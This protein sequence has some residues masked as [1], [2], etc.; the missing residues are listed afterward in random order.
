REE[1]VDS[2]LV[3]A[4]R[5]FR[6]PA[7]SQDFPVVNVQADAR[8][9]VPG[10]TATLIPI[11]N[12]RWLVTTSGTRGGPPSAK[13]EEFEAFARQVR[14]PVVA[15]LI[16]HA[17]PLTDVHISRSTVNR[18]RFFEALTPWPAG[19]VAMGDAVA[20]YNPVYGHGMTVAAQGATA[21]RRA[22]DSGARDDPRLARRT[23][24]AVA[25]AVEG[26]WNLATGQDLRYPG[27]T[28]GQPSAAARLLHGYMDRLTRTSTSQPDTA[29]ALLDAM[30]LSRPLSSLMRPSVVVR[31]LR[32]PSRPPL[33]APPLSPEERAFRSSGSADAE[34]ADAGPERESS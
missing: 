12:G 32:G 4:T 3:Y 10:Q 18:R 33:V 17:E 9:P 29:R 26:P 1:V 13:A 5:I 28:G 19:F 20:T 16:A 22:L 14:D 31:V 7:G 34:P 6:A 2:G 30:T 11:E 15:D 27:A 25:R 24:R 23:Q 8:R 21:L